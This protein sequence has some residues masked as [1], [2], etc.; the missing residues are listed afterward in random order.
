MFTADFVVVDPTPSGLHN[1]RPAQRGDVQQAGDSG[2]AGAEAGLSCPLTWFVHFVLNLFLCP[3]VPGWKAESDSL[4]RLKGG[5]RREERTPRS[6]TDA[7]G[8]HQEEWLC[9]L[10]QAGETSVASWI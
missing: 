1:W 4:E 9:G 2:K 5:I 6:S 10:Q 3:Q 7:G 8:G